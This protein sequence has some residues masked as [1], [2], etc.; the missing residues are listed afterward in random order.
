MYIISTFE[1]SSFLELAITQLVVE[2]LPKEKIL[3]IPLQKWRKEKRILDSI[4]Q[5][6]GISQIDTAAVLGTVFMILGTIYGFV[7]TWGPIIWGLFG[8]LF[9]VALGLLLDVFVYKVKDKRATGKNATDVVLMIYCEETQA[10][11][12]EKNLWQQFALGV[13]RLNMTI[14]HA[15]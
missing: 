6:D 9:G 12:V 15:K 4:H 13:A 5:A 3:A 11:K 2:G 10:D 7:W 1:H 14:P 8:L